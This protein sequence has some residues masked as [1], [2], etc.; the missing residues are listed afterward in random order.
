MNVGIDKINFYV[1][2]Y[3]VDMT[4]LALAR[5]V[6]PNKFLLGIGQ[7]QMAVNPKT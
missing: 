7:E 6:D 2:P 4:E 5:N 1:P 3:Y